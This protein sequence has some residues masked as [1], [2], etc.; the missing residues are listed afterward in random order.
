VSDKFRVR[1]TITAPNEYTDEEREAIAHWLRYEAVQF[2]MHGDM[3]VDG[4]YEVTMRD[5]VDDAPSS[6]P[7]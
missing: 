6:K 3:F 1:L 4:D 7:G 5:D 2:H